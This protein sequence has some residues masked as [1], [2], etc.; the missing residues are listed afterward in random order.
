[1]ASCVHAFTLN[2]QETLKYAVKL[3]QACQAALR[4]QHILS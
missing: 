2:A 3:N 4:L 1:M